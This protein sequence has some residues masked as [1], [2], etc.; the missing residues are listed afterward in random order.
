MMS[1]ESEASRFLVLDYIGTSA[2]DDEVEAEWPEVCVHVVIL[3]LLLLLLTIY[4][5]CSVRIVWHERAE[6][7]G[8]GVRD[9][10][11]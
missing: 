8:T 4:I 9:T 10:H 3:L 2:S 1:K 11:P 6:V 7:R 5:L